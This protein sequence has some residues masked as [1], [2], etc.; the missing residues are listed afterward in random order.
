VTPRDD[1][2]GSRRGD[3][4]DRLIG[5]ALMLVGVL[6]FGLVYLMWLYAPASMP[7]PPGLPRNLL[8]I[9]SPLN[10]IL[11]ITAIGSSLMVLLGLRRLIFPE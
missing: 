2:P 11:P 7:A 10:C 8:P 5:L 6:G 3:V 1:P 9:A 4:E